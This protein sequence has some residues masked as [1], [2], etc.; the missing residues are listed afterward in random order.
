[1]ILQLL[2]K[3]GGINAPVEQGQVI[4]TLKIMNGAEELDTINLLAGET[5]ERNTLKWLF[6]TVIESIVFKILVALAVIV[7]IIRTVNKIRY[8][9]RYGRLRF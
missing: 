8:R 4:G 7:V 9:Q 5:V 2:N 1:M 3:K 6:F